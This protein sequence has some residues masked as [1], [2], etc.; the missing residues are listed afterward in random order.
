LGVTKR[1]KQV[2]E[3]WKRNRNVGTIKKGRTGDSRVVRNSL[4]QATGDTIWDHGRV[5]AYAVTHGHIRFH[6]PAVAGGVCYYQKPGG[7]PGL[8]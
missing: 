1:N 7:V 6:G 3:K 5:L 2:V 8:S 4:M